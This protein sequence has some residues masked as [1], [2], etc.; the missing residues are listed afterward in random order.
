M[1]IICNWAFK[2][3][4]LLFGNYLF[5]RTGEDITPQFLDYSYILYLRSEK[6]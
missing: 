4:Y 2:S 3:G 5:L 6:L 1:F